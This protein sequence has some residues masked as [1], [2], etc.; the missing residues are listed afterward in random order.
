M[1]PFWAAEPASFGGQL[2]NFMKNL[3]IMGGMLY[4]FVHGPGPLSLGR[5]E[6]LA[7]TAPPAKPKR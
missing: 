1:H 6:W 5:D 3:A 7:P 4:V 2:N